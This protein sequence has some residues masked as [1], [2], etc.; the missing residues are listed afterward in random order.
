MK[1]P[2]AF[3]SEGAEK[4]PTRN[5]SRRLAGS[6]KNLKSVH[7]VTARRWGFASRSSET[8]FSL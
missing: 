5:R 3:V 2:P 1:M 4:Q 6:R 7:G 8:P